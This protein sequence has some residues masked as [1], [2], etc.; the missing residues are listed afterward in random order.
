MNKL[1]LFLTFVFC[2]CDL[3]AQNIGIGTKSPDASALLDITS[4]S[5]GIL[6]PRM[7]TTQRNAI[8]SPTNGLLVYDI[9][10]NSFWFRKANSWISLSGSGNGNSVWQ[11]QDSAVY[12]NNGENVGIGT[13]KPVNKLH[14]AGA[15]LVNEPFIQTNELPTPLQTMTM[16]NG[17]S[18]IFSDSD[19]TGRLFDPGGPSGNYIDNLSSETQI[20]YNSGYKGVSI[21][22][23]DIDL[24]I[25]DSLIISTYFNPITPIMAFTKDNQS[26][27]TFV[28]NA[29][30]VIINFKSNGD[31]Q[32]GRGF[33][34][35]FKRLY[36]IADQTSVKGFAGN[37]L[38]FDTKN[39]AFRAG[40]ANAT[41][42]Q[43]VNS[44][45]LGNNNKATGANCIAIG[46]QV[47]ATG[48]HS[49]AIGTA[50][51]VSSGFF[52]IALGSG[53]IAS[54]SSATAMGS[55]TI[56]SGNNTTAMGNYTQATNP[57][58][59]AMG[60]STL[61]SGYVSTAMGYVTQATGNY[62]TAMG[63]ST[64]AS[65]E[66]STAMGNSTIASGYL[67][68]A[69]GNYTTASGTASTAM[70]SY[71]STSNLSG[72]FAIGDNSTTTVMQSFVANGFRAR[73]ASG[74]RLFTTSDVT[75]GAFL[76]AGANSWAA[77]SDK[78]MKENFRTVN[79]E[80]FLM[81]ISRIPLTTWNYIGQNLKTFRHYGPMAQDF[82]AAFGK[83]ELGAIG[84]DTL[85][86]QQD[87]L[88]VNLI[89]IQA[90]EKRTSD[91][92]MENVR[93]SETL[94]ELKIQNEAYKISN[95]K[96]QARLK[97][98]ENILMKE[99]SSNSINQLSVQK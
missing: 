62:S 13:D 7:T 31:G 96:L 85:I 95:E 86:N 71:V 76:N 24:N 15:F 98:L 3:F 14:V 32:N 22:I 38:Y 2:M 19:S 39:G 89:A 74:Y 93:Q 37:S 12:V 41:D 54:G 66:V 44:V 11:K 9:T 73:F 92:K 5:K 97:R 59:T 20:R 83:D 48:V 53:V 69:M 28:F 67:S 77:L 43:A 42:I 26:T 52:S 46:T 47:S 88:G 35:I 99:N 8:S 6:V 33:N 70:G 82:F 45:A 49:V 61:A 30:G 56:A 51:S 10:D 68:T 81:K 1:L 17:S 36:S 79:G 72:A 40:S 21:T 23:E 60:A 29:Y 27:G 90:L 34:L 57:S 64:L 75:V 58:A 16:I 4:T 78:R 80:D 63:E 50:N 87:F 91:L 25:G 55:S 84:C 65:G 18:S 94:N